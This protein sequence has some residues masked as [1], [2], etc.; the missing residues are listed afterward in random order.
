MP[1]IIG[2][3]CD[4]VLS[5]TM[6]EILKTP[7]FIERKMEREDLISYNLWEH[8]KLCIS[9]EEALRVFFDFFLSEQYW[10]MQPVQ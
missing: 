1:K 4:D 7:L 3:D 5:E 2:V 8:P 9:F 10:N 6:R